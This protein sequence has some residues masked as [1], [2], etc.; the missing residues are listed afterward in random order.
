M[1]LAEIFG[2][3]QKELKKIGRERLLPAGVVLVGGGARLA[4]IGD[5]AREALGLPV[6]LGIAEETTAFLPASLRDPAFAT[7]LG[8][9]RWQTTSI[10]RTAV[11]LK[12][13]HAGVVNG[14]GYLKRFFRNLLP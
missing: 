8:L 2:L 13:S 1:Y 10:E 7:A 6:R 12:F 9:V 5:F 3:V 14:L 4:G 11:P